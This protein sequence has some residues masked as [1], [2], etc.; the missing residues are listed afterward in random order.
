MHVAYGGIVVWDFF[1]PGAPG[2][3]E[4]LLWDRRSSSGETPEV[5]MARYGSTQFPDPGKYRSTR[6]GIGATTPIVELPKRQQ[7]K[8]TSILSYNA[9]QGR[10]LGADGGVFPVVSHA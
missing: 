6:D 9:L 8:I 5:A 3:M 1:R 4:Q 7:E 2:G 10:T